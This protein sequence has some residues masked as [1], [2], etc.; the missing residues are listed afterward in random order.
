MSLSAARDPRR[1]LTPRPTRGEAAVF[2]FVVALMGLVFVFDI[3]TTPDDVTIC[4][5]YAV[6][7]FLTLFGHERAVYLCTAI[8]TIL[9]VLGSFINPPA[10]AHSAVFLANRGIAIATQ[11]IVA[12]LVMMRKAAE[13][14]MR[15]DFIA[16][17][18]KAEE[19]R[20]FLDVLSH[21]IGT[22]LTRIDGQAFL[23]RKNAQEEG[24][25]D[26]A[27]R[28]DKIRAAV[29][30][31]HAVVQQIQLGSEVGERTT[32]MNPSQVNLPALIADLVLDAGGQEVAVV[33]DL[34]GLPQTIRGDPD[35]LRQV[36]DN[37]LSNA[38]KYSLP[39]G[40]VRV[41]GLTEGGHAVLTIS[42]EGRGIPDDEQDKVFTPYY[43]ARNSRG[44]HG[45]GIGLYVARRF[46]DS[47]GGTIEID[48]ALN[49][50]T[51]VTVRFPLALASTEETGAAAANSLH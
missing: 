23:L 12:F 27:V 5:I 49:A 39:G 35:L 1:W 25:A 50:G 20:R 11:W 48:S 14:H 36:V 46:V 22:S 45:A 42:D 16:E 38:V 34:A 40:T 26:A 32:D 30:H 19:S 3:L 13:A 37:I 21:E 24:R 44:V 41:R 17:K 9:S 33:S 31:I 47:H 7:V 4:F 6:L 43:R 29:G 18:E 51:T 8:A 10:E 2:G 15:R 28:A